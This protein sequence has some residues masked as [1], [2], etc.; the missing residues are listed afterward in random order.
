MEV[1]LKDADGAC[2]CAAKKIHDIF[3]DKEHEGVD[4]LT[5]KYL[6]ECSLLRK[7]DHPNITKFI[8]IF[9]VNAELPLLIME[10]LE[11]SLAK[12]LDDPNCNLSIVE[13]ESILKDVANGLVY[14]HGNRPAPIIHRDLTANNVL[15]NLGPPLVAKISDMGNS[16]IIE[17]TNQI[18]KTLS[19]CPGTRDYMPPEALSEAH[20]YG[21]SLDIFSFG[22]LAL[23]TIIQVRNILLCKCHMII[24]IS[25]SAS[26]C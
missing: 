6:E 17:S 18:M 11:T 10:R 2:I 8:G 15:L 19:K 3:L 14:L 22:H 9:F 12:H 25:T 7:L 26:S 21:P 20:Q 1:K 16:R 5:N 23:Y 13:K 4:I 24:L